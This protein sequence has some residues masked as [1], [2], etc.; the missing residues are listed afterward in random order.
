M[1]DT[2][3]YI[4]LKD[5]YQSGVFMHKTNTWSW[6]GNTLNHGELVFLFLIEGDTLIF[7]VLSAVID[8]LRKTIK[9]LDEAPSP[10]SA[11]V[12]TLSQARGSSIIY[13]NLALPIILA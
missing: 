12:H 3:E 1:G 13:P 4:K 6:H 11:Q 7:V 9:S 10:S 8:M 5:L 2:K